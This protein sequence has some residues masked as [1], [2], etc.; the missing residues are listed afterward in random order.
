MY[1]SFIILKP[2]TLDRGLV[3]PVLERLLSIGVEIEIFDYVHVTEDLIDQHYRENIEKY[4]G[5]FREKAHRSFTGKYVIPV[6]VSSTSYN[7]IQEIRVLVGATDPTKAEAGTI[8]A[9]YGIDS[10][11][12]AMTE[13]RCC[14]N[15]IH[16]S[17]SPEAYLFETEL[18]FGKETA[19]KYALPE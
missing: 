16:A 14:E 11:D 12:K 6:I 1:Y 4:G 8:R 5:M 3:S 18:W 9:D 10:I 17:D 13:G 2:E 15:L 7:V 19:S